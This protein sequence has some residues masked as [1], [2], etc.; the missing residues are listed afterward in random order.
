MTPFE[1]I[2]FDCITGGVVLDVVLVYVL[3]E[4]RFIESFGVAVLQHV[5][6]KWIIILGLKN[7]LPFFRPHFGVLLALKPSLFVLF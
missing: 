5:E 6:P 4:R 7:M 1:F 2:F 3:L